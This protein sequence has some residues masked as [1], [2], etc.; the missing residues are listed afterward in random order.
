MKHTKSS[1]T[2]LVTLCVQ[3]AEKGYEGG[4]PYESAAENSGETIGRLAAVLLETALRDETV[5]K[6]LGIKVATK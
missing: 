4:F 2:R 6:A 1:L 5:A 3:V